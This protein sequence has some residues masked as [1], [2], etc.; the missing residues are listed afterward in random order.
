VNVLVDE[1]LNRR[2]VAL[3]APDDIEELGAL[4]R[5]DGS[6]VYS[7]AG[8]DL[9]TSQRI[10]DAEQRL[11]TAAGRRGGVTVKS[12]AVDLALLE[13]AANGTALDVGQ[14]ALVRQ[15]CTSGARLQL[16]IAPA[17]AV[18]VTRASSVG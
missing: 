16:A 18:R 13:M 15:M 17:G 6:S 2:C 14:A 5:V 9:Y 12:T 8:A 4:R 1:V 10:L 11:L 7:V 3:V